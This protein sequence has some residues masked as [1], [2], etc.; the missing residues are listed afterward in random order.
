MGAWS[1]R[2]CLSGGEKDT[3]GTW[4]REDGAY[5]L[6]LD[7]NVPHHERADIQ[8]TPVHD[9]IVVDCYAFCPAGC[10][11]FAT[12]NRVVV[13]GNTVAVGRIDGCS[14]VDPVVFSSPVWWA[15][16]IGV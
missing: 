6:C 7:L 1:L 8:G 10:V 12:T 4:G 16:S 3:Q 9:P 13:H 2:K 11:R 15:C 5:G 14:G